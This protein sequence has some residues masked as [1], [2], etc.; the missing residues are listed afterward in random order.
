[1][2]RL[3]ALLAVAL[4]LGCAE[5]QR[6]NPFDPGNPDTRGRPA[7]FVAIAERDRVALRWHVSGVGAGV[8]YQ[9]FRRAQGEL[10]YKPL[11]SELPPNQPFYDDL[12]ATPGVRFDYRLYYVLSGS[13]SGLPAEDYAVPGPRRVWCSDLSARTLHR[14]SADGHRIAATWTGFYGPTQLCFDGRNRRVWLSDTYDGQV[15][16]VDPDG[17]SRIRITG[18][19][20]PVTI[21]IDSLRDRMWV[22][23]QARDAVFQ[24]R[25]DGGP[26]TP[27]S[28]AVDTPIGVALDP[29]DGTIWVCERGGNRMRRFTGTGTPIG[30]LDLFAPSRVAVDS[31]TQ[32]AW[33]TSFEGAAVYR[34]TASGAIADTIA[35]AGPIGIAV[36]A[37]R[38]RIWVADAVAGAVV[39]LHRSGVVQFR[40][41]G[42]PRVRELVVE[43]STGECF[44]TVPGARSVTRIAATGGV[45]GGA[46]GFTD[47]YGITIEP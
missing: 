39:A 20:E 18:L 28:L 17:A 41:S 45:I 4:A 40:V 43:L 13:L 7:G 19:T 37:R 38:G 26:R 27:G 36:D 34:I 10:S 24:Y 12:G 30:A 2:R 47:P 3:A 35:F 8:G 44:A 23:D 16:S 5:R 9:L 21:A 25:L 46:G 14:L 31:T 1:M 42:L 33:V 29:V 22:C 32:D 15:V 6:S 11:G